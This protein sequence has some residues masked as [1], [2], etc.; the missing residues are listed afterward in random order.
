MN[1]K[2]YGSVVLLMLVAF[3]TQLVAGCGTNYHKTQVMY[4][5]P[6][7]ERLPANQVARIVMHDLSNLKRDLVIIV[8][9]PRTVYYRDTLEVLPGAHRIVLG[10]L[11]RE[12]LHGSSQVSYWLSSPRA[13]RLFKFE[14]KS[15]HLYEFKM[16]EYSFSNWAV[17]LIDR[18][19]P[20]KVI[21]GAT[22]PLVGWRYD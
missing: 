17:D 20:E 22:C 1:R 16:V 18:Q 21:H 8:D 19:E 4:G 3:V 10:L 15:G 2:K 5:K 7:D 14:V 9:G 12:S 11:F 13:A 6:G